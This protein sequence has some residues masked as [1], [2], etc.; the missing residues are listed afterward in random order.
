MPEEDW[1][2][3]S[4]LQTD[5][6]SQ[7]LSEAQGLIQEGRTEEARMI[8]EEVLSEDPGNVRALMSYALTFQRD[9]D[10]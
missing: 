4:D 9:G 1:A 7:A 10:T 6:G 8:L 3:H 2:E 5:D